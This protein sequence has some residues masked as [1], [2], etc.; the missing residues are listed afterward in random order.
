MNRII[1]KGKPFWKARLFCHLCHHQ[2]SGEV[3]VFNGDPWCS[4]WCIR[5]A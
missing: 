1:G 5:A 4:A 2:I 3:Y